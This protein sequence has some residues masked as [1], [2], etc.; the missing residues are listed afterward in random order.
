MLSISLPHE[1]VALLDELSCHAEHEQNQASGRP[2]LP[3]FANRS[4]A[5]SDASVRFLRPALSAPGERRR[6]HRESDQSGDQAVWSEKMS[7]VGPRP[8]LS[9]PLFTWLIFVVK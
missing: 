4:S 9:L 5:G 6:H 3:A 7:T 1:D 8:G 2:G